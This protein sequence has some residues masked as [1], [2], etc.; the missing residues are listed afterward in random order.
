M[1][2][3]DVKPALACGITEVAMKSFWLALVIATAI[4][5]YIY[6]GLGVRGIIKRGHDTAAV[7]NEAKRGGTALPRGSIVGP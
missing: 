7:L 2:N 5:F 4:S 3:D 6:Y 1:V